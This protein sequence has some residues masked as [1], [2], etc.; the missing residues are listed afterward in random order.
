MLEFQKFAGTE[1]NQHSGKT[2]AAQ[3]SCTLQQMQNNSY[4]E[5]PFAITSDI[6]VTFHKQMNIPLISYT[7]TS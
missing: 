2:L 7:P 6:T 4:M 1:V 5:P 3:C